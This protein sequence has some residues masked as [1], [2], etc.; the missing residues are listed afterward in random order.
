MRLI[1]E[2]L[3]TKVSSIGISEEKALYETSDYIGCMSP[4][5]VDFLLKH[6]P[7]IDAKRVEVA[8]NSIDLNLDD[9]LNYGWRKKF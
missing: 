2:C 3:E 8:P 9:N 6:N 1:W 7:E 5:N 4:A